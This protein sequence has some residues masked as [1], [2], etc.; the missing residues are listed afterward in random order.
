VFGAGVTWFAVVFSGR[1]SHE[2]RC[3]R[4]AQSASDGNAE[5]GGSTEKYPPAGGGPDE[6]PPDGGCGIGAGTV[7]VV[8]VGAVVVG[9]CPTGWVVVDAVVDVGFAAVVVDRW[10]R[11]WLAYQRQ[12]L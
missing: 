10:W 8:V 5:P 12:R 9:F 11:A 6:V 2:E 4:A 1:G 7:V 3:T